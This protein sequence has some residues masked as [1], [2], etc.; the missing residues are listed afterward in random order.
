MSTILNL[1]LRALLR[2]NSISSICYFCGTSSALTEKVQ[3]KIAKSVS[4]SFKSENISSNA[5]EILCILMEYTQTHSAFELKFL[6]L[7]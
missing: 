3:L 5:L 4:G 2:C 1:D 7:L 6:P